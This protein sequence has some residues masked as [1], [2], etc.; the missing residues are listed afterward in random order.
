MTG[1]HPNDTSSE[2]AS[3][4]S[5]PHH[6]HNVLEDLHNDPE[7]TVTSSVGNLKDEEEQL[8]EKESQLSPVNVVVEEQKKTTEKLGYWKSR[9]LIRPPV[10]GDPR[11]ELSRVRKGIILAVISQA[12]CLGGFSS[13]I[14]VSRE[15]GFHV[16]FVLTLS[17]LIKRENKKI[18]AVRWYGGWICRFFLFSSFGVDRQNPRHDPCSR[19]VTD[20]LAH[21]ASCSHLVYYYYRY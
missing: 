19:P 12:G 3:A 4:L 11:E 16:L 13:T 6:H 1:Q 20:S 10:Q 18:N 15:L 2:D 14:Y 17:N 21:L 8:D 9:F 5:H 7:A